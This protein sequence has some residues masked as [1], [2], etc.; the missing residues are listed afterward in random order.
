M[1]DISRKRARV[2][3]LISTTCHQKWTWYNCF[4]NM[5]IPLSQHRLGRWKESSISA[6]LFCIFP[7]QILLLHHL[8]AFYLF[9]YLHGQADGVQ[10]DQ[11]EHQVLKIGGV[12]HVP[13]LVLVLVFGDVPPQGP[14][15]QGILYTLAL[16]ERQG[17]FKIQNIRVLSYL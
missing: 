8:E 10:Q 3:F 1:S 12:D 13:N 9:T 17:A 4:L 11:N 16:W 2:R 15:F 5:L 6:I 7:Q 14:G